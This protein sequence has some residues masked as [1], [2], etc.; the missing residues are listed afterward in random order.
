M[1]RYVIKLKGATSWHRTAAIDSKRFIKTFCGQW[2]LKSECALDERPQLE[3]KECRM[4]LRIARQK[5]G[6]TATSRQSGMSGSQ[7]IGGAK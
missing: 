6:R 7:M 1:M 2:M 3:F 4:C 5:S